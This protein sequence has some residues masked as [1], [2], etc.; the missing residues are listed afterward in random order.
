LPDAVAAGALGFVQ[1]GVRTLQHVTRSIADCFRYRQTDADGEPA[2]GEP[3]AR[4]DLH[5]A[6]A[7]S[8][9]ELPSCLYI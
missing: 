4:V 9:R 2:I 5:H 7:E 8:F 1:R 6:L 3:A